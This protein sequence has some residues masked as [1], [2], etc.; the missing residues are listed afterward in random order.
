MTRG[1]AERS[2]GSPQMFGMSSGWLVSLILVQHSQMSTKLRGLELLT[3]WQAPWFSL[4]QDQ[5]THQL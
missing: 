4:E 2:P 3:F 1:S 5:A